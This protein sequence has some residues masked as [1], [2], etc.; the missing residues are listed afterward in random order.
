MT[1]TL[2]RAADAA[3]AYRFEHG[4]PADAAVAQ[5]RDDADLAR[6]VTAYRFWYPTVSAEGIF[7]GSREL[8]LEDGRTMAVMATSPR[9]VGFTLNSDT[10][11]GAAALDLT[12][13]PMVVELPAGPYIGLVD[14]HHQAWIADLGIPGP[15][16]GKGGR[17]VILPPGYTG[18]VPDGHHVGRAA[19]Y[20]VLL[21][22]RALPLDGNLG[23]ALDALRRIKVYPLG[24]PDR[25]L[26]I[27]D[28]T[29]R[30]M[31]FTCLRWE[32]DFEFWQV[33]HRVV[34]TEPVIDAYRGMYGLLTTLGIIK[35]QPFTP[36]QRMTSIL[37][38]AARIGRDQLLVSAFASARRD[39]M[40]WPDR[41]W[42]WAGLVPDDPDFQTPV[43]LDLEARDRWFAQAIVA[44][45]AMFR[46]QVGG[47]SLY[48]LAARDATGAYL[49]GG[50]NYTL[51]VPQP[52]PA[53]LFWSV[54][55]YDAQTRS[56]VQAAQGRAALR[57]LVELRGVTGT[58]PVT[59]HFGP[60][61]PAENSD[62]H[63]IQTVPGRGWFTY[64]RIYGP[65]QAAFDGVWRPGDLTRA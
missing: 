22:V 58:D 32:D 24:H 8:G 48:W 64:L 31:D 14:D 53:N 4:Y 26:E 51:V 47:G 63:W 65:E 21:A 60:T 10:P 50:A 45:P 11:Y 52:V 3:Q 40:A 28:T 20:K 7:N 13:G 56:Q 15:D 41:R 6:A 38:R 1:S 19:T 17:H 29:D 36:D 62:T 30:D 33:L 35:G 61:P 34:E 12:G 39:R 23:R 55:A 9:Q 2:P 16:A 5:I 43:G 27:V 18:A 25:P 59:L 37:S 42:E 44:S 49:D 57:S 54:T 46:R